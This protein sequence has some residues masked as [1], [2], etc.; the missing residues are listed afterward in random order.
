MDQRAGTLRLCN[1]DSLLEGYFQNDRFAE[2]FDIYSNLESAM[3]GRRNQGNG[4]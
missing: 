4:P 3:E 2:Q 1:L